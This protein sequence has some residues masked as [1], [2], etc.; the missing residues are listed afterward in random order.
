M[1][2]R[3]SNERQQISDGILQIENELYDSIRPKRKGAS[4]LRPIELLRKNGI[5]YVEIRGIDLSPSHPLGISE[6]DIT[7]L[8]IFLLHC[9]LYPSKK[10]DDKEQKILTENYNKVIHNGADGDQEIIFRDSKIK[11]SEAENLIVEE[12]CSIADLMGD[13]SKSILLSKVQTG[14]PSKSFLNTIMQ[15]NKTFVDYVLSESIESTNL[16]RNEEIE[17][18]TLLNNERDKSKEQLQKLESQKTID[19]EEYV[20]QY[21]LQI[22]E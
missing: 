9:L 19:L 13:N 12:L 15:T 14:S 21:N 22:V 20:K 4:G 2:I 3:D 17:Q 1:C 10:I 6:E 5:E 16:L 8:D 18:I 7:C 11:I